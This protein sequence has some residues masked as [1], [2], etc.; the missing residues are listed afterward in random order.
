MY[1][2]T[3]G[4]EVMNRVISFS[5]ALK[6][7]MAEEMRRDA[8]VYLI[9][10]DLRYNVWAATTG[11]AEEFGIDRVMH[12]PI[13][14]NGFVSAGIGSALIGMRPVVELM[15][16]DFLLLAA[17]S[18][19]VE[20]AKWRYINGGGEFKVPMV[21]RAAGSGTGSGSGA[22]H[23]QDIEATFVHYPGLKVVYP[24]TPYDA[25]GLLKT[26]I[27]DNNPVIFFE[28]KMLYGTKGEVPEE[29]YTIEFGKGIIRRE[30]SDITVVSWG[31]PI[32]KCLE[33]AELLAKKG[34]SVEVIDP[35]TLVP[36]DKEIILESVEKTNRLMIVEDGVKRGG[37]GAEIAAIVAEE[38]INSLDYPIQRLGGKDAPLPAGRYGEKFM[39]P[40]V[41]EI[42]EAIESNM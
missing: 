40:S 41:D 4:G 35:R 8:N 38:G 6:E 42:V 25:K 22:H 21:I 10:Q 33:A 16:S 19:V 18:V 28:H 12:A 37:F 15:Y 5:A 34:I 31:R 17:D 26:A 9:G 32:H 23:A 27:R 14:E 1:M 3:K 11:L 2:P 30:G 7:A 24:S 20:A 39:V 29:E 36:F 13:S